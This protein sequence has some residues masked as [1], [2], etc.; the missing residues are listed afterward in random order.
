M[1]EKNVLTYRLLV[2]AA[3]S[4]GKLS[5]EEAVLLESYERRL[6]VPQDL[7]QDLRERGRGGALTWQFSPEMARDDEILKAALEVIK[8]DNLITAEEWQFAQRVGQVYGLSA[9]E[10]WSRFESLSALRQ[11]RGAVIGP[12]FSG[13]L[14][15]ALLAFAGLCLWQSAKRRPN[16]LDW[17]IEVEAEGVDRAHEGRLVCVRG[18]AQSQ[19]TLRDARTGLRLQAIKLER[20]VRMMQWE[21][22]GASKGSRGLAIKTWSE[23]ALA[24]KGDRGEGNPEFFIK[25]KVFSASRVKLGAFRLSP[26]FVAALGLQEPL[27]FTKKLK[28]DSAWRG[29]SV[30]V[31]GRP[32]KI[33]GRTLRYIPGRDTRFATADAMTPVGTVVIEYRVHGAGDLTI[34]GRQR[35]DRLLPVTDSDGRQRVYMLEERGARL[36]QL[37]PHERRLLSVRVFNRVFA[38]VIAVIAALVFLSQ[39]AR[40]D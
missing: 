18:R 21:R 39:A 23:R 37:W 35:G 17:P 7:A 11:A 3:Y 13:M 28:N 22:F 10:L 25:T 33:K 2:L 19:D 20:Q 5:G 15:V 24:F 9:A 12:R 14:A 34:I 31:Q 6:G 29:S 30:T 38:A 26:E 8:A 16:A 32:F 40:S 36:S 1:L 27:H 4:D